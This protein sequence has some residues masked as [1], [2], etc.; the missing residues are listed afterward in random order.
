MIL[1]SI[2]A[3]LLY[4][5]QITFQRTGMHQSM[6]SS[7]QSHPLT[8]LAICLDTSISSSAMQ[9]PVKGK[10]SIGDMFGGISILLMEPQPVTFTA[11]QRYAGASRLLQQQMLQN[12]MVLLMRLLRNLWGCQM[13]PLLLYSSALRKMAS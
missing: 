2:I 8:I 1:P 11:I 12:Y 9:S 5:S 6:H 10:A 13:V 4:M 7:T 3:C